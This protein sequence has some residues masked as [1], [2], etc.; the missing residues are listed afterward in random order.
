MKCKVYKDNNLFK[1]G[2]SNLSGITYLLKTCFCLALLGMI[3]A[4]ELAKIE[5]PIVVANIDDEFYVELREILSKNDNTFALHVE[6]IEEENCTNSEIA[7]SIEPNGTGYKVTLNQITVPDVCDPGQKRIATDIPMSNFPNGSYSIQVN[8]RDLVKNNGIL[9]VTDSFYRLSM[10][11]SEGFSFSN[12]TLNKIPN[13][14]LWGYIDIENASSEQTR[15]VD[16]F[17]EEISNLGVDAELSSGFYGYFKILENDPDPIILGQE[18]E[19]QQLK[20]FI[21]RYSGNQVEVTKMVDNLKKELGASVN[22]RIFDGAG[23][24]YN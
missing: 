12:S 4:C 24:Q 9:Q 1:P 6:T 5:D 21:R 11:S 15:V 14:L 7:F 23:W 19:G 16:A 2:T 3:S 13:D 8:L 22:V 17:L 20:S 18:T 10:N